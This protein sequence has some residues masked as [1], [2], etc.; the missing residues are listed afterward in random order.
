MEVHV[1]DENFLSTVQT[2]QYCLFKWASISQ[3]ERG[4]VSKDTAPC[5]KW[6]PEVTSCSANQLPRLSS[7][8][9]PLLLR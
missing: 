5:V 6:Y 2:K 9:L 1:M 4:E 7:L 3:D 8:L